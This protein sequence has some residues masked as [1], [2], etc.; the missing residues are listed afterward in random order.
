MKSLVLPAILAAFL[1]AAFVGSAND[2]GVRGQVATDA[3][4]SFTWTPQNFAGFYYD[5]DKNRG[6]EVLV[7]TLTEGRKLAGDEPY[8]LVY[9][10]TA[11]MDYFDFETWGSYYV[12]GFLGKKC[13]AGYALD[14]NIPE[15]DQLLYKESEDPNSLSKGQIEEILID[16]DMEMTVTPGEPVKLEDGYELVVKSV[17]PQQGMINLEL[18]KNGKPV[19]TKAVFPNKDLATAADKTYLYKRDIGSQRGLVTIAVYFKNAFNDSENAAATVGGIW[20]ISDR[21][22][23]VQANTVYD[24]MRIASTDPIAMEISLDNSG[25][26]IFL[27]KD[28][29]I[30][31]MPGFHIKVANNDTLRYYP[32][33]VA[34]SSGTNEIRSQLATGNFEWNAQNFAGFYYDA[35]QDLGREDLKSEIT[36][37]NIISEYNGLIYT[38]QAQAKSFAFED[39]GKYYIIGFL[40]EKH[41]AGYIYDEEDWESYSL[42]YQESKDENSMAKEQLEKILIDD[43]SEKV[44]ERGSALELKEGYELVIK[45]VS[46]DGRSLLHLL[47]NGELVDSAIIAPSVEGATMADKTYIYRKD[48]G[49]QKDLAIIAVYFKNAYQDGTQA[50]VTVDGIWQISDE[51]ISIAVDAKFGKMRIASLTSNDMMLTMD[52]KDNQIVLERAKDIRLV[53]NIGLRVADQSM[54]DEENPAR[55][56]IYKTVVD[57]AS[58][59]LAQ[60][61]SSEKGSEFGRQIVGGS[62]I[63]NIN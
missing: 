51:P 49:S 5:A 9:R 43:D 35:D 50:A 10:S 13:L 27:S 42:L 48:V 39:W 25:N 60:R 37:G 57:V 34:E 30:S 40:G 18:L 26:A 44:V 28:S 62:Q 12:I 33:R 2:A 38:T 59:R 8:G 22:M 7:A 41:F 56:Y 58:D 19:D 21:P 36:E 1:L 3:S 55:H 20:Q 31:T 11:Q 23:D 52:N 17:Q 45:G 29:D 24:K 61:P 15:G 32:Y 4:D 14:S 47:K 6:T 54:I 16:Q 63:D 53:G 46:E